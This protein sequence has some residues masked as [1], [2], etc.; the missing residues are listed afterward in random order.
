MEQNLSG[1]SGLNLDVIMK[2]LPIL[3]PLVMGYLSREKQSRSLD[4]GGLGAVLGQE[5]QTAEQRQPG[6]GGLASI[7]DADGDGSIIDDVLARSRAS[8]PRGSD[9][10]AW[11]RE[12]DGRPAPTWWR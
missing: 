12:P 5:R 7:L 1:Q 2:L 4:A 10:R 11:G 3:A 8:S 9:D 6:L